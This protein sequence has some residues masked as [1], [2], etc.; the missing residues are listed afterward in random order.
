MRRVTASLKDRDWLGVT[1]ELA[2]VVVGVFL[3]IQ[4]A[5]WNDSR[6]ESALEASYFARI[7]QDVRGD[8]AEMDEIIR[9]SAVRMALL[10]D[11]LPKASRRPLPDGFASARGRV[12]IEAVP[13]LADAG[14]VAPGFALFILTPLEGNRSA[15]ETMIHA[16]ALA[17]IHDAATLRRV[18]D[19]YAAADRVRHFEVAMERSRDEL[20]DAQR[21]AGQSPVSQIDVERIVFALASSPELLASAENYWLYTNR[22]LKLVRA[23]QAQARELAG[24]LERKS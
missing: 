6:K 24:A 16:G 15:Y 11:A 18:Q 23:L 22:H 3:G 2:L 19:Y 12:E 8:V 5:N 14:P 17:G 1:I 13:P 21:R 7:A 20:V 4:V 10:N 9:V